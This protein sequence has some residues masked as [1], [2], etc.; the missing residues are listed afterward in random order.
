MSIASLAPGNSKKART[1]A[2]KSFTTFLVAEDMDLPTAFQLIDADKTGKVL[3]IMLDKYAYS[4]AKS[5]DKVLATNT[6]LAYYGNVKNWLVDKY[7]LQGGL[8]K[9]QLQKILSSLGKYCNNREE[10]GNEKK[11]PPCSKQDLEGIVRLL[12]TSASTHSEY[13][14]AALV[15]MMWYL[16][17][18]SSDAEQVE[19]QQLSVLPGILIFCAICKRS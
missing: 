17:G 11:A 9:P 10:S 7:P 2:I 4:L 12:Y 19:K 15:V 3:R 18:R 13:L 6:C 5:Q 16:Y 8:V 14:D 1:T